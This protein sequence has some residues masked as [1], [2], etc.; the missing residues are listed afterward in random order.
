M[1]SNSSAAQGN[2]LQAGLTLDQVEAAI[3]KSGY[4]LQIRLA[5]ELRPDF[6]TQPEWGFLDRHTSAMRAIDLMATKQLYDRET[7]PGLRVR[8][9]LVLL[10]ECKRSD[11]P[12]IFFDDGSESR[13]D[14]PLVA[15]LRHE[16]I[17]VRTD[18]DRSS[19][20]FDLQDAL[21][22]RAEQFVRAAEANSSTLSKGARK[23][24]GL[25]LSGTD[26]YQGIVQP[27]RSA[28]EHFRQASK[29]SSTAVYFDA[30]LVLGV[31]VLDAPM[32]TSRMGDAG[33]STEF[34][35]WQ[36]LWRHEP[37]AMDT[38]QSQFGESSAI[39]LVHISY[40]SRYIK[41]HVNPFAASFAAAT[42]RHGI[43]LSSGKGFVSGLGHRRPAYIESEL[44]PR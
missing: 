39:D 3:A 44:K 40:L 10:I 8:P 13:G 18:D 25:E 23:G 22:L 42:Q 26:A 21:G 30:Y 17:E 6:Q 31:A 28:I 34:T 41:D 43:E 27:L 12:Y 5:N 35:S 24:N 1:T 11:M 14:F 36:R 9:H 29:P 33:R 15:G 19:W 32:I 16:Q 38:F 37:L 20:I 4:P 7:A 2:A